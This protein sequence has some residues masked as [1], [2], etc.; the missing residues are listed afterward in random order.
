MLCLLTQHLFAVIEYGI[1]EVVLRDH[2]KQLD[3]SKN[4]A[5]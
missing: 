5:G 3:G 2:L 1:V 4:L